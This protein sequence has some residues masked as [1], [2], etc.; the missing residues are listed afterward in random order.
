MEDQKRWDKLS[1]SKDNYYEFE[2]EYQNVR[3]KLKTIKEK[4]G[5]VDKEADE[6]FGAPIK[7]VPLLLGGGLTS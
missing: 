4:T 6:D 2:K 5:N 3:N 1:I 7:V